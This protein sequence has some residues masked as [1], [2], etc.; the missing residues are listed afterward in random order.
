MPTTLNSCSNQ[1]RKRG[2]TKLKQGT[3]PYPDRKI[4]ET[5]LAFA[6]PMLQAGGASK[7]QFEEAL[8]VAFTAWNAVVL[9]D[10]RMDD[11]YLNQIRRLTAGNTETSSLVEGLIERKRTLFG[12]DPR[13][14]GEYRVTRTEDGFNLWAEARSPYPSSEKNTRAEEKV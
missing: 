10:V 8:G 11:Q 7:H 14:I 13:M 3:P 4:S 1:R 5:F 6:A 9:A 12:D 2:M